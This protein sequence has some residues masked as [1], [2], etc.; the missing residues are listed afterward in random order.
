MIKIIEK[1]YRKE[2]ILLS[3]QRNYWSKEQISKMFKKLQE[4]PDWLT[5]FV[6]TAIRNTTIDKAIAIYRTGKLRHLNTRHK[7]IT[8]TKKAQKR[9][10]IYLS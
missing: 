3:K 9:H 1:I 8:R 6:K 7:K 2:L 5:S 10:E 4:N